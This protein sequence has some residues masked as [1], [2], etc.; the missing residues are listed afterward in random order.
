[1]ELR[2][3]AS[4]DFHGNLPGIEQSADIMLI[5]GDTVPLNIQFNMEKSKKWFSTVFVDWVKS[6]PVDKVFLVAGN[7]DAIFQSWSKQGIRGLET[8]SNHK[9]TYLH[10]EGIN[11]LDQYGQTWNIFGTPYC[12]T[13]GNW[14]FELEN[15]YLVDKFAKIPDKVDIIISHDPPFALCDIDVILENHFD[16]KHLGNIPLRERLTQVEYKLL[17]CGHIHSG[18]HQYNSTCKAVNV[19]YLNERYVPT[20]QPFYYQIEK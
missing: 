5:A 8:L 14:P 9:L 1:M 16:G 20:Y 12:H 18:D 19:S 13:L 4:S 3:V 15:T 2:I 17:V 10:N 7:H 6:L 11:Y